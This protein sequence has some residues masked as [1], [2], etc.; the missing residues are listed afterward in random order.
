MT[1]EEEMEKL[2]KLQKSGD[3]ALQKY[4]DKTS[5]IRSRYAATHNMEI[6]NARKQYEWI[7]DFSCRQAEELNKDLWEVLCDY[8]FLDEYH[9]IKPPAKLKNKKRE[10][11]LWLKKEFKPYFYE[12]MINGFVGVFTNEL[13][14]L[15]KRNKKGGKDTVATTKPRSDA[16]K[17][18]II[19][20]VNELIDSR[21]ITPEVERGEIKIVVKALRYKYTYNYVQETIK[22]WRRNKSPK[23]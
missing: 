14:E 12:C 1:F 7:F 4:Y 10:R 21:K 2:S 9:L 13:S 6:N 8:I 16:K 3:V 22:L 20:K 17:N 15:K 11:E 5:E 23:C 18:R 19:K